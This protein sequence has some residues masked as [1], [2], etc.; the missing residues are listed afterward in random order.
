MGRDK[1]LCNAN[2]HVICVDIGGSKIM[3]GRVD[4]QGRVVDSQKCTLPAGAD[5][6]F[7]LDKIVRM[8]AGVGQAC[9]CGVA[10]PGLADP[11]TGTWV[12][13]PFSGISDLPIGQILSQKLSMPTFVDNDVNVCA[14]G[15]LVYGACKETRNFLWITV[16][17]GIGGG[18]VLNGQLYRGAFNSAGEIGH[19]IV[20]E[21]SRHKCG[22]GKSGCLEAVAS[23]TGISAMFNEMTGHETGALEIANLAKLGQPDAI[24]AYKKAAG[25]IG[26]AIGHSLTLLNLEKV[27]LGGG[28]AQDFE[29][30]EPW[31][32]SA[33]EEYTFGRANRNFKIE[34]TA[35]GYNAALIGCA[36][37]ARKGI[38][39]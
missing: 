23:G 1:V 22:C 14:M 13:A 5:A 25:F 10:I 38:E 26:K 8:C 19:F 32:V 3:V 6:D 33:V 2:D 29:L 21:G 20:E 17:N 12:Y 27:I 39:T 15:E 18:L 7:V 31:L 16:S 37:I 34:K 28:V 35:L 9:C 4:R 24:L 36:A 30:F 11:D